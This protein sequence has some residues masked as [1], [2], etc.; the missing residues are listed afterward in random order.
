MADIKV[1]T[2]SNGFKITKK[3]EIQSEISLEER[4]VIALEKIAD[5]LFKI[6][7]NKTTS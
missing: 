7:E 3:E 4:K 5:C 6:A 2:N 1:N